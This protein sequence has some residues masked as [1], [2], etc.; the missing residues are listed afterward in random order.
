MIRRLRCLD[1]SNHCVD[2]TTKKRH[3]TEFISS[4]WFRLRYQCM[5]VIDDSANSDALLDDSPSSMCSILS[6]RPLHRLHIPKRH[7]NGEFVRYKHDFAPPGARVVVAW[8]VD[9]SAN[10]GA[11][12]FVIY[13]FSK[14]APHTSSEVF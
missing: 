8:S 6:L 7:G 11:L 2:F 3:G 5:W 13:V 10:N 1:Y 14:R 4:A 12:P 9:D